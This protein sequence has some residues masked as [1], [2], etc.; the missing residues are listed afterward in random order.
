MRKGCSFQVSDPSNGSGSRTQAKVGVLLVL[1]SPSANW[2]KAR[3]AGWLSD[4]MTEEL[5]ESSIAITGSPSVSVG[6][7]PT[8]VEFWVWRGG[9]M[10]Q[11]GQF[12]YTVKCWD[13]NSIGNVGG[14]QGGIGVN[15]NGFL[16]CWTKGVSTPD[17]I[18]MELRMVCR[19]TDLA[20]ACVLRPLN[21]LEMGCLTEF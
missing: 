20:S 14:H 3:G 12:E 6:V 15:S 17:L 5:G 9:M 7:L 13:S 16:R 1:S 18:V 10:I 21:H 19:Q 2:L 4:I 11:G 8:S